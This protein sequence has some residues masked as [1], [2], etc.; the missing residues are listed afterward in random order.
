MK[1]AVPP[2]NILLMSPEFGAGV[3]WG[4]FHTDAL[5]GSSRGDSA[6]LM[7]RLWISLSWP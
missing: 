3:I 5:S 4:E 2:E 1:G 7:S 6:N